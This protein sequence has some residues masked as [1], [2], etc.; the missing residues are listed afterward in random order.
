MYISFLHRVEG[1]GKATITE[2]TFETK[3]ETKEKS[4]SS[5]VKDIND[6]IGDVERE[7]KV[8]FAEKHR[9][10]QRIEILKGLG[11]QIKTQATPK[12]SPDSEVR[13]LWYSHVLSSSF[14][15]LTHILLFQVLV[16]R[17]YVC[18]IVCSVTRVDMCMRVLLS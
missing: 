6:Q 14:N 7:K 1:R 13:L 18:S 11:N 15:V 3:T 8:L 12:S 4:D 5:A 2:V 9:V 10:E 16:C 17:L